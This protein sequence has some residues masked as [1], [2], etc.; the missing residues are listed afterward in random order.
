MFYTNPLK[1][2]IELPSAEILKDRL[3]TGGYGDFVDAT[4]I[5]RTIAR[6]KTWDPKILA[7]FVRDVLQ[8]TTQNKNIQAD[9]HGHTAQLMYLLCPEHSEMIR[10]LQSIEFLDPSILG[11]DETEHIPQSEKTQSSH[12]S[13]QYKSKKEPAVKSKL[14]RNSKD[15]AQLLFSNK[16]NGHTN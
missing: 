8:K 10:Y 6:E 5:H 15:L 2:Q 4:H 13:L 1:Q 14:W 16:S 11:P 7:L 3:E 9:V 12:S